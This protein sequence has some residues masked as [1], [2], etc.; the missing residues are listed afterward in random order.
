MPNILSQWQDTITEYH[1][2]LDEFL[3]LYERNANPELLFE[4]TAGINKWYDDYRKLIKKGEAGKE[5][6]WINQ[7][8]PD[9]KQLR[10]NYGNAVSE[11]KQTNPN[12][13]GQERHFN[14]K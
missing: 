14:T 3:R 9:L 7:Y 2:R 13:F 11:L 5:V 6:R 8:F 12:L 4:H 10:A 1:N